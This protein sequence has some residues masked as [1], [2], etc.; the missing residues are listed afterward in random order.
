[1]CFAKGVLGYFQTQHRSAAGLT[2]GNVISID[3]FDG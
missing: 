3:W 1:M 2:I